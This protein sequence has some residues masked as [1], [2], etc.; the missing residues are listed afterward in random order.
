MARSPQSYT[1]YSLTMA[2]IN[3]YA[4]PENQSHAAHVPHQQTPITVFGAK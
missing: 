1:R 2:D 3:I 4:H